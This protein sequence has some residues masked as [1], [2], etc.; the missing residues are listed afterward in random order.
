MK[1]LTTESCFHLRKI[2]DSVMK[3]LFYPIAILLLIL[4]CSEFFPIFM[5]ACKHIAV[6]QWVLYGMATYFII[7]RFSFF[8]RNEQWLQTTSHEATH[9][10][11]GMMFFHKIHSLQANEDH[12]VVFHSGKKVGDIFISLAPYCLPILTYA[13][14]L[15]R[16]MGANKMLYVFDLFIGFTLAFH[17]VCFCSQTRLYQPDIQTHGYI[18]SFLFL[19]VAWFFNATIILLSIRKGIVG[20]I[21]YIF[22]KYWN[23]IIGWWNFIF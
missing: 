18:K 4:T 16:I 12:G 22:P 11:V 20:A 14:L 23:D 9:A 5:Y 17:L 8:S 19:F 15:L 6:Y 21:T 13:F 7:R 1:K 2:L 3:Y 10:I